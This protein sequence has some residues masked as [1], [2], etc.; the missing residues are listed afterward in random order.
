MQLK[1]SKQTLDTIIKF[2]SPLIDKSYSIMLRNFHTIKAH[3]GIKPGILT[4]T[5]CNS[6][7]LPLFDRE[8]VYNYIKIGYRT[9]NLT[10]YSRLTPQLVVQLVCDSL[11]VSYHRLVSPDFNI[12]LDVNEDLGYFFKVHPEYKRKV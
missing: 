10:Y 1:A 3:H 4:D 8:T 12:Y 2:G 6:I 11:G 5:I 7:G 9:N